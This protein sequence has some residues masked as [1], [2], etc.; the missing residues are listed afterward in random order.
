MKILVVEDD[1]S[2]S[3]VVRKG[4]QAESHVVDTVDNGTDGSFMARTYEYDTIVLDH[5]LPGKN[6]ITICKDVRGCGKNTPILFLSVTGDSETKVQALDSGADD[7]MTKPFSLSELYSRIKAINRRHSPVMHTELVVHDLTL[8]PKTH[9]VFRNGRR[10][11][12]TGKEFSLLEYMMRNKSVVL[13]RTMIMEHVW[14]VDSDPFSNTVEAHIRNLRKKINI[15]RKPDLIA[16]IAGHG[17]IIDEP[18][19]LAQYRR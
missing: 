18:S 10:V 17:Y 8:D 15:S 2:I 16:N 4:L 7:Y 9:Q 12:L 11:S 19:R 6:G 1:H 3:E 14:T 5:A 13:S